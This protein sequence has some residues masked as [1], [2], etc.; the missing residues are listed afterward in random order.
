MPGT[1]D[2]AGLERLLAER[3]SQLMR[4]A[5]ALT[6]NREAGED[7]MQAA[8]E[9]VLRKPRHV[10]SDIEAYLRRVLYNLAADGWRRRGRWR[11]ALPLLRAQD[12]GTAADG[13]KAVD[14]RDALIRLLYQLP[15][16]QRAVIVLRYWEQLT[17]SSLHGVPVRETIWV[18][19]ITYLP[20]RLSVAAPGPVRGH[21]SLLTYDYRWLPPTTA[22][23]AAWDA[24]IRR[25]TMPAGF[26]TLPS[27]YLPLTGGR[28]KGGT[29]P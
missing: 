10:D 11:Q 16:R 3:G 22:N 5:I 14:L 12:T 9:R 19:P 13:T 8:L 4:V 28:A 6:G 25:A 1:P 18:N 26:R 29:L 24:A 21:R 17:P 7:L 23:L 15:A 2:G 27:K 20:V